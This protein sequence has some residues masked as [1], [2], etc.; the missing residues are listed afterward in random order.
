MACI[1]MTSLRRATNGDWFSRKRIPADVRDAYEATYGVREEARFRLPAE[2]PPETA[3][4][5]FRDWD[6]AITSRIGSLRAAARG[7]G[8]AYL[9]PRQTGELAGK[10]YVWF[11]AHYEEDPGSPE[12]WEV[13][14]DEYEAVC[15]RFEPRDE[16][17]SAIDLL[18]FI[19]RPRSLAARRAIHRAVSALGNVERFLHEIGRPLASTAF[20]TLLDAIEG[21][22][23]N[24][25][26]LL[27]RRAEG[28]WRR[29]SH[30]DKFAAATSSS[31]R[32]GISASVRPSGLTAWTAFELWIEG[33]KPAPASINR[34]RSVFLNLRQRFGD[35]DAAT[36]TA[37][38]AQEWA[39]GLTSDERSP[40]V[41]HEVWLKAAKVIFR[42]AVARTRLLS[43]PFE[44][45]SIA[46]PKRPPKLREREFNEDEWRTMLRATLEP[47]SGRMK[48]TAAA[49]RRWVPWLCA[50][51]GSRPGEACQLRAEDIYQHSSGDFWVMRITPEAGTVKGGA[52]REVPLHAHLVD[53][54]FVTFAMGRRR[55]PLFYDPDAER[56]ADSDP[57]NPKRPLYVK[58]RDKLAEWSRSLGIDDPGISPMHAWRHTFNRRAARAGIE[59]RIRF[60]FCGHADSDEGDS[61]STPTIEDLAVE[62]QRFP[63]YEL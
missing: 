7:E 6:A 57:T 40:H 32:T 23:I 2:T 58:A 51:T 39:E 35:R 45:V 27:R 11:V 4:Q 1:R 54:G 48:P 18:H 17:T 46:L 60:G 16:H 31:A 9:T 63:K 55:G 37:E 3:K 59:R 30:P 25:L 44:S 8:E 36:I 42:W 38:E 33:K 13:L 26:S 14:A 49:A 10:W 47:A 52:A 21:E 41:V 43:S 29:D 22:F 19:E 12:Q 56:K 34:W 61:Y 50:Y 53:Q 5:E 15:L 20:A 24:A 62:V 28:D